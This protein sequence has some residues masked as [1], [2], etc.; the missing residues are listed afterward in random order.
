MW[1]Y[2][3]FW[4]NVNG[5]GSVICLLSVLKINDCYDQLVIFYQIK[6]P[7]ITHSV[8]VISLQN[9]FES[10][11]VGTVVGIFPQLRIDEILY[12]RI[13]FFVDALFLF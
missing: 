7:I 11:D 5:V 3:D 6:K 12:L 13:E 1:D 2:T 8:P 4:G 10:F 9:A